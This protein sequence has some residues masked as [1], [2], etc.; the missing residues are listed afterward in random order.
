MQGAEVFNSPLPFVFGVDAAKLKARYWIRPLE[1][2]KD[3]KGVPNQNLVLLEVYPKTVDDAVNYHHVTV[4]LDVK[5]FLPIAIEIALTNW[6][7][8]QPHREFFQFE[9]RVLNA[10]LLTKI[11]ETLFRQAFIPAQPPKDWK[12]EEL[13]IT[14]EVPVKP[15]V[16]PSQQPLRAN[17]PNAVPPR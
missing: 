6:T 2:P 5:E 4:Y 9:E 10:S 11:N 1:P 12:V 8:Q 14:L 17:N 16:D 15:P 7:P 13:P 3:D